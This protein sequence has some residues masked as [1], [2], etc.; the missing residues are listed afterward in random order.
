MIWIMLTKCE[1]VT[2]GQLICLPKEENTNAPDLVDV[3]S[4]GFHIMDGSFSTRLKRADWNPETSLKTF[5]YKKFKN[6]PAHQGD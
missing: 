5:F 3:G 6:R 4:C 2:S 1:L